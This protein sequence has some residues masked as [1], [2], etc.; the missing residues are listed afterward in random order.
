MNAIELRELRTR[1]L[2]FDS[3]I[4]TPAQFARLQRIAKENEDALSA[5]ERQNFVR[6]GLLPAKVPK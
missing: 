2:G 4:Y 3:A 5:R 6:A 1:M